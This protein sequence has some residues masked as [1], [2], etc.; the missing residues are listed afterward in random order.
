MYTPKTGETLEQESGNSYNS[1]THWRVGLVLCLS[2]RLSVCLSVGLSVRVSV[3]LSVCVCCVWFVS[4]VCVVFVCV[5][6][7]VCQLQPKVTLLCGSVM[8][9]PHI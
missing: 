5:L 3:C 2:V 1:K 4:L 7:R 8:A 6:C 9:V